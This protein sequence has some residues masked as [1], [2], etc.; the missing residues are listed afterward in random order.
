MS[1]HEIVAELMDKAK[2]AQVLAVCG[3]HP[4]QAILDKIEG[5]CKLEDTLFNSSLNPTQP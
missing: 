1:D 2:S 3:P 4:L 5:K